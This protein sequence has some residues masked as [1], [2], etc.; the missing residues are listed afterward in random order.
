MMERILKNQ[1]T[2]IAGLIGTALGIVGIT[3]NVVSP[4]V[5]TSILTI[6]VF[7]IGLFSKDK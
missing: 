5:I 4:D 7:I 2:T 3:T 1:R 6:I